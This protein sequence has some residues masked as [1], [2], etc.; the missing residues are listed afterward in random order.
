MKNTTPTSIKWENSSAIILDQTKLP[1][2]TIY[3]NVNTAEEMHHY[4]KTLTIRGAGALSIGGA[5]G[6]YL[7]IQNEDFTNSEELIK[8]VNKVCDF[9]STARPTAVKLFV[10][11][12]KIRNI[13]IENKDKN[14]EAIKALILEKCHEIRQEN[15]DAC[16]MVGE[17]ALSLLKDGMTVLT[18]CNAGSYAT[19]VR[20]SALAPFYL[21]KERGMNIKVFADETR[22]LLQGARLTAHEL[23]AAGVDVTL[24][25]DNM[26]AYCMQQG[27]IDAVIV[28]SDRIAANGDTVN[29]IG[30]YNVAVLAKHHNIPFYVA[31]T[32]ASVDFSATTGADIPI[33]LR[34]DEEITEG[35]G[36]RT[37]PYGVKVYNPAFDVTPN[38]LIT[39]IICEKGIA[40]SD[41]TKTLLEMKDCNKVSTL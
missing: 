3:L 20:G 31:S 22:P 18:H 10:M 28:S 1:L 25:C 8:E 23:M 33:E 27:L 6:V 24:I 4:I 9:M 11:I 29:K 37:A 21:A 17:Y 12:E 5:Y 2:E 16:A 26:A 30:T 38:E 19:V 41:Y 35:F 7:G 13:A 40:T 14:P 34:P 15:I 32:F 39:A 36:K